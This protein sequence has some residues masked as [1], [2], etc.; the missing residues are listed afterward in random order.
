MAAS[1]RTS[2]QAFASKL[3]EERRGVGIADE[4]AQADVLERLSYG[5]VAASKRCRADVGG[6]RQRGRIDRGRRRRRLAARLHGRMMWQVY[7]HD[8]QMLS[9]P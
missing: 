3:G 7:R 2:A 8:L 6:G 9:G 5:G 1:T 4:I